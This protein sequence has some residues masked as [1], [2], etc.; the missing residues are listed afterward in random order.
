MRTNTG[1]VIIDAEWQTTNTNEVPMTTRPTSRAEMRRL[2]AAERAA[3]AE[4]LAQL[5]GRLQPLWDR[6]RPAGLDVAVWD[7]LKPAVHEVMCRSGIGGEQSFIKHLTAVTQFLA[8]RHTNGLSTAPADAFGLD[9][10]EAFVVDALRD[11]KDRTRSDY[12]SRL[13][14]LAPKVN[15]NAAPRPRYTATSYQHVRPPYTPAEESALRRIALHQPN[16]VLRR[17]VCGI[18]GL[19]GGGGLDARDLRSLRRP[20]I[21]IP[22]PGHDAPILVQ[23][24]GDRTRTIAVRRDYEQLVRVAVDGIAGNALLIGQHEQRKS[25]TSGVLSR[26]RVSP[27]EPT[28]DPSRLRSTWIAWLM[29]RNV[30][31]QTILAAAGLTSARTLTDLLGFLEPVDVTAALVLL[32]GTATTPYTD[33]NQPE[34]LDENGPQS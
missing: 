25:V 11:A 29:T 24:G 32:S 17:Q 10:I 15:P 12:Q 33:A 9:Q 18:V 7:S 23:V 30:P 1:T 19:C 14:A 27:G 16:P 5:P 20:Q 2:A 6:Y 21:V 22:D 8:Y 34:P 26:I 13:G 3:A 31:L 4:P 28:I